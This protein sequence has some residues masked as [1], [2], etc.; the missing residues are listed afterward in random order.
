M[1]TNSQKE[2]IF[3]NLQKGRFTSAN[4]EKK[5]EEGKLDENM[6]NTLC[7][8]MESYL[9]DVLKEMDYDSHLA[10]QH[11]S[12]YT[13][14]RKANQQIND[15]REQLSSKNP[16]SGFKEQFTLIQD[17]I[18][19]WWRKEGFVYV[20][21]VNVIYYGVLSVKFGFQLSMRSSMF[22][23]DPEGDRA[24]DV[25]HRQALRDRGFK[26]ADHAKDEIYRKELLATDNNKELLLELI[27][28]RFPSFSVSEFDTYEVN[29]MTLINMV[30]GNINEITDVQQG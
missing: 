8:L 26:F 29:G 17:T 15:L 22:S 7:S 24:D 3:K 5:I 30:N 12:R 27:Q 14:I 18:R 16:I 10:K 4:L 6:K 20:E 2:L 23:K 13:E 25:R 11:D 9:V 28:Q 19:E 21:E 1:L